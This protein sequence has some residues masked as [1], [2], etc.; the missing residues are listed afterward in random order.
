MLATAIIFGLFFILDATVKGR[1]KSKVVNIENNKSQGA[2][3]AILLD[4]LYYK[5]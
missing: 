4:K 2:M 1:N 5:Q 3:P